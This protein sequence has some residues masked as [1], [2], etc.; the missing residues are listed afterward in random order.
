MVYAVL[1]L[2]FLIAFAASAAVLVLGSRSAGP[3]QAPADQPPAENEEDWTLFIDRAMLLKEESLSTISFWDRLLAR[4]NG[5]EIMKAHI[6]EAGLKWSVGRLT[7]AMLL[8]GAATWAILH[9]VSWIPEIGAILVGL[10]AAAGPYLTI[11]RRRRKNLLDFELHF[12]D[13]L[14]SLARAVRAGNSLAGGMETL[15]R[16]SQPP[17]S[18]EMRKT[19]DERNLGLSW[20]Q[21]L[22][23]LARRVPIAEVS[24]FA[25]AIQLQ[26]RSGGRLHEVLARLA[27]TMRESSSL[28]G[29][30][31]AI[32]AHGK[33]TGAILTIL[34]LVI[35][36]LMLYVNPSHMGVLWYHPAGKNMILGSAGCLIAAHFVIRKLVDIRI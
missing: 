12:P 17:V 21:A 32:A 26:S 10:V 1:L 36:L 33:A 29:E 31:R 23:N 35:A 27:E 4:I 14:D 18:L 13:A 6:G 15:A 30:I 8:G 2:I 25:A 28:K 24:V 11:L 5:V 9:R 19:L 34:P 22:S 16:E 3:A 20:E 7:L